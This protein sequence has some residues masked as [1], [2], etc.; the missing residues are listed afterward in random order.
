[1]GELME[2]A[3]ELQDILSRS[4]GLPNEID[5]T[6]L[7]SELDALTDELLEQE[8][9]GEPSYLDE[10]ATPPSS[11]PAAKQSVVGKFDP[12]QCVHY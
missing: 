8:V 5:E 4:Y 7:E 3:D 1:M 2:D 6:E 9:G 11:V 12:L 10:I